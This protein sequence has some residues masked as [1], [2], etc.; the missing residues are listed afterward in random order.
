MQQ[1][2]TQWKDS[3][4]HRLEAACGHSVGTSS[5]LPYLKFAPTAQPNASLSHT[6]GVHAKLD[7]GNTK[8][9]EY[10]IIGGGGQFAENT[11]PGQDSGQASFSA[12]VVEVDPVPAVRVFLVAQEPVGR[13]PACVHVHIEVGDVDKLNRTE[14]MH[15]VFDTPI[16]HAWASRQLKQFESLRR[17]FCTM[18]PDGTG[19][20]SLKDAKYVFKVVFGCFPTE[21]QQQTIFKAFKGTPLRDTA[22][23][24]AG[25][26]ERFRCASRNFITGL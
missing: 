3:A 11:E 20:S 12:C 23:K 26:H 6:V 9:R 1:R 14:G 7:C 24:V 15:S 22:S 13:L 5:L 18:D 25:T 16:L 10:G 17:M 19:A 2:V 8:L 21:V 4:Q